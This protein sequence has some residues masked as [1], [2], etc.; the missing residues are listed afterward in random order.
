MKREKEKSKNKKLK[1][2]QLQQKQQKK[3]KLIEKPSKKAKRQQYKMYTSEEK[4]NYFYINMFFADIFN[5]LI[6]N[7]EYSKKCAK[8]WAECKSIQRQ[9]G[10]GRKIIDQILE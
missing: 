8:R 3:T 9:K 6:Q 7:V 4:L 10:G 2:I 5:E 1:K